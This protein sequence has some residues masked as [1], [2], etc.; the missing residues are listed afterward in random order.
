MTAVTADDE[1]APV[2]ARYQE[3]SERSVRVRL[4]DGYHGFPLDM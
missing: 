2:A 4:M 3:V 1:L